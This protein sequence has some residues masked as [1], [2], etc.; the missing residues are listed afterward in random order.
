VREE[1]TL[2]RT[3]KE[4][5]EHQEGEIRVLQSALQHFIN[6]SLKFINKVESGK[7]HSV[8]TYNDLKRAVEIGRMALYGG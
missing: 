4:I 6:V 3:M 1:L 5:Q 2:I 8:E 7:A